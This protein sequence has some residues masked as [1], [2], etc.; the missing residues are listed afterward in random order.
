MATIT[1]IYIPRMSSAH[2]ED[3]VIREI[4]NQ[5]IGQVSRVDFVPINKKPG[6]IEPDGTF[7]R[8]AFVHFNYYYNNE[9]SI[10]I[11]EKLCRGDNHKIDVLITTSPYHH[12]DHTYEYW[13]LLKATNPV[14]KTMMNTHQ[15]VEN[16]RFLETKI[17]EQTKIIDEQRKIIE[18]LENKVD[19]MHQVVYQMIGHIF[20][21]DADAQES[22][23]RVLY[24][25]EWTV[26]DDDEE[27]LVTMSSST[28]SSMP[29]LEDW[30][31]S[32]KS[33]DRIRISN[34]LCGN[35]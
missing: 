14:Q 21:A 1:S 33:V 22:H 7:V 29:E 10:K 26:K 35:E 12:L 31:G 6:F 13:M 32:D 30:S 23:I 8:S 18:K 24:G 3:C 28:H 9:K 4:E 16:C 27:S 20:N 19:G 11:M 15:I 25:D 5:Q 34:E 2:D 17:D